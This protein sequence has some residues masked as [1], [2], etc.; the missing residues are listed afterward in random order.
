MDRDLELFEGDFLERIAPGAFKDTFK[1]RGDQIRVLY[2]HGAD[3]MI[4]NKPLGA[5]DVLREDKTGAYYEV[6]LFDSSYVNDLKPAI[7]SGQLGASFRFKVTGETW[8]I[9]P[10]ATRDNPKMLDERT[11]TGV[12]LY[13]FGPV[14]FPAYPDASAGLRSRTDEFIEHFLNDPQFVARFKERAGPAVVEQIRA[15]LPT[16]GVAVP[17]GA[18][19]ARSTGTS[20]GDRG[21]NNGRDRRRRRGRNPR[22]TTRHASTQHG[23]VR[24]SPQP[25]RKVFNM[26]PLEYVLTRMKEIKPRYDTLGT[27]EKLEDEERSEYDRAQDRMG[28]PRRS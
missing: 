22:A 18:D 21:R 24:S 27:Q 10:E 28:R 16:A 19:G 11:I 26:N 15:S 7:R 9:E 6:S 12:D 8:A 3:P 1:A 17:D 23:R 13:E 20:D 5:P 14:T 25:T 4:G 2:D